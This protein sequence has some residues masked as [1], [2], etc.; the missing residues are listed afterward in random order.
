[1]S[2]WAP[3]AIT[4]VLERGRQSKEG[5]DWKGP[6]CQLWRWRKGPRAKENR[7]AA[8]EAGQGEQKDSVQSLLREHD[9]VN[10]MTSAP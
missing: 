7:N 4:G 8:L 2:P 3:D 10:T 6:P 9:P 1:M 5:A